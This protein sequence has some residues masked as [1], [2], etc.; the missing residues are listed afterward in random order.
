MIA[1]LEQHLPTEAVMIPFDRARAAGALRA[2]AGLVCAALGFFGLM[3]YPAV[4]VGKYTAL[5]V[6]DFLVLI[7]AAPALFMSWRRRPFWVFP[8]LMAPLCVSALKAAMAGQD[9]LDL[10]LKSLTV[11]GVSLA[12]IVAIQLCAP[13]YGG[14]LLA[15]VAAAV[16][17]HSGIGLWQLYSFGHGE[18]PLVDLY[19]NPSFLSVQDNA[20]TIAR[21]VQRPF[22]L[23][24]EPSAMAA[25]LAPWVLIL[26]SL[27]FELI[28]LKSPIGRIRRVYF[29][30]AALAGL[31]LIIVS[32]SGHAATT[33]LGVVALVAVWFARARA[34]SRTFL[35]VV[36]VFGVFLPIVLFLAAES[37]GERLGGKTS[38]GNSS[39]GERA[40]S[41][42][43]GFEL[44][45]SSGMATHLFGTGVGLM[46]PMIT[47]A[48]GLSAVFSVLLTYLFETGVVGGIAVAWV[49][50]FLLRVWGTSR[51]DM[52]FAL[53]AVVW[54]AGITVITSYEQ[55]LPLWL[56]LGW[57]TVWPQICRKNRKAERWKP[58]PGVCLLRRA[59]STA[60]AMP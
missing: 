17:V 13:R 5:Q 30:V 29:G 33:S 54:L 37:V 25:S 39:W 55:L 35:V 38:F 60:G 58:T 27:S 22:G 19:V 14:E 18:L 16:L 56:T 15:G 53:V 43:N 8:L 41:L 3:P 10:C 57:L 36:A 42:M 44:V 21:Y 40:D 12:A 31:G 26:F 28:D 4:A 50:Y 32:R 45:A 51:F 48:T 1:P 34:N 59:R 20:T 49:G 23:F 47:A 46:S 2:P 24:P 11:W 6:G 9:G 52:T 7:L